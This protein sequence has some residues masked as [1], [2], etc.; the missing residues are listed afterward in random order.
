MELR[1]DATVVAARISDAIKMQPQTLI[2]AFAR[3]ELAAHVSSIFHDL[4][5][6]H[7][8]LRYQL[9]DDAGNLTFTSSKPGLQLDHEASE[10]PQG[11]DDP[12]VSIYNRSG[13]AV[14]HF[15]MLSI[16]IRMSGHLDGTLLVYLDQSERAKILSR[17]YGPVAAI[18]MLLLGAGIATPIALAW[19]RSREKR[20]AEE[21]LR[22]LENYDPLTGFPNRNAFD[23]LL[24]TALANMQRK[25]THIAVLCV[26]IGK[27]NEISDDTAAGDTVLREM[28]ERI[29]SELRPGDFAARRSIDEFAVALVDVGNLAEVMAL[30]DRLVDALRRPIKVADKEFVCAASVGIALAPSDGDN[31]AMLL[32]HAD[33]ALSRAKADGGQRM[34]CFEPGMDK[35]LQRRRMIEHEL[36]QALA[37]E[38]FEVVYQSQHDLVSG[39]RVGVE[40][41]VRWRHPVHGKVAPAHFISVAEETGLIVP[42]GE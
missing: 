13:T 3:S 24:T 40:A 15:A 4:G 17:Y 25:R 19:T 8:V 36:R 42:L 34:R 37:R 35:A 29:R 10:V 5:Y 26:D 12:K 30:T 21:R 32:R 27:L 1:G 39:A 28:G 11:D 41:L 18:T 31:A 6:D 33:I 9:Y 38:E 7:R 22:Y 23:G 2:G 16:P 20:R 14:S